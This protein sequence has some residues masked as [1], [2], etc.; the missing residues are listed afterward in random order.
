MR[1]TP[2]TIIAG[3]LA[4]AAL[5]HLPLEAQGLGERIR[6]RAQESLERRVE[7]RADQAVD[8]GLDRTEEALRCA[9]GEVGCTPGD[10]GTAPRGAQ[11]A[12]GGAPAAASGGSVPPATL[13]P[14]EGAWANYDF[15]PGETVLFAEDFAAD[16]VGNF[17]RRLT[18]ERGNLEVVEWRG[19][20][21]LRATADRNHFLV[22]LPRELPERF[23]IEFDVHHAHR[24]MW[25][26]L[27]T[28]NTPTDVTF[29]PHTLFWVGSEAGLRGLE[30][31]GAEVETER[32]HEE[33]VPVRITVDGG[34]AKMFLGEQR[35]AN[36]PN[37]RIVRSNT[38]L[39]VV[40]GTAEHPAHIG[41]IRVAAGGASLYDALEADGRVETQG[42]L[43][44]TGSD[45]I[46]PE[47][48]PTL[49]EI[50]RMLQ[51]HPSLRLRI[52]GHTD[53]VGQPAANQALSERRAAAVRAHLASGH[54]IDAGRL[55]AVGRGAAEPVDSNDTPEGRQNNRRVVLVRL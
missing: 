32:P 5:A 19:T 48:T 36:V 54:G 13:R 20:R 44:D 50:A 40:R 37:A 49:V 28:E 15:V 10:D 33:L 26:A 41:N 24:E 31:P 14:G 46:R 7:Q 30:A 12:S 39:F 25:T 27:M 35:I 4:T 52:E 55:E 42:I 45:R 1:G 43:F 34:Y 11:A 47:S 9:L 6:Q 8:A 3:A 53:G 16:R 38:L 29:Y 18:F 23:T 21:L 2:I 17:P 22:R 51:Q